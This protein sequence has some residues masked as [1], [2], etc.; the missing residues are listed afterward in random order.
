MLEPPKVCL[1]DVVQP[2]GVVALTYARG[3]EIA[4]TQ[5]TMISV[6]LHVGARLMLILFV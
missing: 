3:S 4:E 6:L 1:N 2:Y 5:Q